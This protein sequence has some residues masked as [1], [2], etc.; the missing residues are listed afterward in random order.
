MEEVADP[1]EPEKS[2]WSLP[3]VRYDIGENV[4]LT[5]PA[6]FRLNV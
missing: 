4:V 5:A 6:A 1:A 2:F 3:A